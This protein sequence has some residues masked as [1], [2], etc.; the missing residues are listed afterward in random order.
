MIDGAA[1]T[2][3]NVYSGGEDA[4]L[5]RMEPEPIAF[6]AESNTPTSYE[7]TG[8]EPN[9]AYKV[10]VSAQN[11]VGEGQRSM[12]ESTNTLAITP[13]G[14]PQMVQIELGDTTLKVTWTA[15]G[16]IGGELS[17]YRV[18][19]REGDTTT[20]SANLSTESLSYTI[21]GL[22]N[23]VTYEVAVES[24]NRAGVARSSERSSI[25]RGVPDQVMLGTITPDYRSLTVNW[26]VPND[27]GAA[28]TTFNVYSG[29]EDADFTTVTPKAIAF[30]AESGIPTSYKIT[31]LGA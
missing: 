7:I 11:S 21:T 5:T 8:L 16:N 19:W 28:I 17:A 2:T 12:E 1:I 18:Y 15:P 24:S 22:I 13:P 20:P 4:D 29:G 6:D 3:F 31:G 25:P 14:P 26:V 23:G 9:T 10:A 30:N 27:R